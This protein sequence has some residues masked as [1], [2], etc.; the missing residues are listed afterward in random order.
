MNFW[1]SWCGR[2][3][4]SN[5]RGR[6]V[7]FLGINVRDNRPAALAYVREFQIPYPSI[8]DTVATAAAKLYAFALPTTVILNAIGA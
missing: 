1:A 7:Q 3:R 2:C 5:P 4:P 8:F 6:P